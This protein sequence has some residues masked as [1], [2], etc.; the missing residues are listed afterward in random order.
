MDGWDVLY[1]KVVC[2]RDEEDGIRGLYDEGIGGLCLCVC[3][4]LYMCLYMS[5]YCILYTRC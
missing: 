5:V 2:M 1:K 4:Y 3:L